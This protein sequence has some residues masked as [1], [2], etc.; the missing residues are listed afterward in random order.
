MRLPHL[1]RY[2]AGIVVQ[3]IVSVTLSAVVLLSS[4]AGYV[5]PT[6]ADE[7][8]VIFLD[9]WGEYGADPGQFFSPSGVA[10]GIDGK[11]YVAD[12]SNDRVQVLD[13]DGTPLATWGTEGSGTNQFSDP[14]GIA[15][16]NAGNIYVADTDNSRV[17]IFTSAG[18]VI[19]VLDG[20]DAGT[21]NFQYPYGMDVTPDG[22][23]L[24]IADTYNHCV[25][26]YAL[27]GGTYEYSDTIG[28]YEIPGTG[29]AQFNSPQGVAVGPDGSVYVADTNNHRVQKLAANGDFVLEWGEPGA[30]GGQFNQPAGITVDDDGNVYVADTGNSRIQKFTED[31]EFLMMFGSSGSGNYRFSYPDDVAITADG[32]IVVADTGHDRICVYGLAEFYEDPPRFLRTWGSPGFQD[33]YLTFLYSIATDDDGDVYVGDDDHRVQKFTS[34]GGFVA[35]WGTWGSG[36]D[37]VKAPF[38]IAVDSE[39]SV[40]VSDSENNRVHRLAASETPGLYES[41]ERLG[42]GLFYLPKGVAVDADDN[43]YVV[44]Y[45]NHR[46]QKLDADSGL[47]TTFAGLTGDPGADPGQFSNPWG[48]AV[49]RESGWVYV[50][51]SGNCRIQ[52]FNSDGGFMTEWG[53]YGP[54]PDE[55]NAIYGIALDPDGNV[56]VTDYGDHCIQKFNSDG[57]FMSEWGTYGTED[58]EFNMPF[59]IAVHPNGDIYVADSGNNRVQ[60][61]SYSVLDS[62]EIAL[63]AGWNMVSVPVV[64]DDMSRD[65]R[66]P[67][68][69]SRLHLE[70]GRQV[71]LRPHNHRAGQG[72]LGGGHRGRYHHGYRHSG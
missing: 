67:G 47:W 38:G 41:V 23:T 45:G 14:E 44:D 70:S 46:V 16:D 24:Y 10:V 33:G 68:G 15:V 39:G 62:I 34:N 28:D 36:D 17:V 13:V 50:V 71:V 40:Y 29:D 56:Y 21:D 66:V 58:G 3:T 9:E 54:G 53:A 26:I 37:Q 30:T 42:E 25:H 1:S 7:P 48:I 4:A 31:G 65:E 6:L 43:I 55:F 11:V 60:V 5:T 64:A 69:R 52:K 63:K 19:H 27:T 2:S 12:T 61:F 59:G 32:D 18:T 35:T 72:L 8:P 20:H 49:N 22:N 51:D 57:G